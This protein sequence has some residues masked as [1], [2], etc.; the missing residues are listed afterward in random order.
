MK[1][2]SCTLTWLLLPNECLMTSVVRC[3]ASGKYSMHRLSLMGRTVNVNT[4]VR[5]ERRF[6]AAFGPSKVLSG[7]VLVSFRSNPKHSGAQ[8]P[9]IYNFLSNHRAG[10]KHNQASVIHLVMVIGGSQWHRSHATKLRTQTTPAAA[11]VHR[12]SFIPPNWQVD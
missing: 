11:V 2:L 7:H 1:R 4:Q 9:Y 10:K 3:T 12:C 8:L 5:P 6:Q